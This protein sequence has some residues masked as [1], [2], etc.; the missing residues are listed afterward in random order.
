MAFAALVLAFTG[1]GPIV[2]PVKLGMG[3]VHKDQSYGFGISWSTSMDVTHIHIT[4]QI[5]EL[6]PL[7]FPLPDA[8]VVYINCG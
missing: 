4:W 3:C 5:S 1:A 2:P 7:E 8:V 6:Q